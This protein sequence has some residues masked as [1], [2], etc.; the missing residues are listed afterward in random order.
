MEIAGAIALLLFLAFVTLAVVA[1]VKTVRSVKRS[2]VR[3]SA[4]ARRMVEDN[5]LRARR[6][7]MPGP[8][9]ELARLRLELRA[10][11]DS[12][13]RALENSSAEDASLAEAAL[14]MDRLNDHARALDGELKMLEGEPDRARI[15]DRVPSLTE[16]TQ[17]ITHAADGLRWA[18]QDRARRF[19]DDDLSALTREIDL[20][21]GALRHWAPV[22]PD[23]VGSGGAGSVGAAPGA[24]GSVGAAQAVGGGPEGPRPG[25]QPG[26]RPVDV[27]KPPHERGRSAPGPELSP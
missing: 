18:A 24:A 27:R 6:Y 3:G 22:E 7:T 11:I 1:T 10:S 15:A 19:A 12:T 20:E 5:R 25:A 17:R 26:P 9:G 14:L 23:S 2:V 8:A 16:R 4:Q 21:A 13:F